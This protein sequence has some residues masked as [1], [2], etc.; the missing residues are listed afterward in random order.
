MNGIG[1]S[2]V[3]NSKGVI[4]S[5]NTYPFVKIQKGLGVHAE[6]GVQYGKHTAWFKSE[7]IATQSAV[8]LAKLYHTVGTQSSAFLA[9][10]K[11]TFNLN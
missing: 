3:I 4:D 11:Q 6:Y 10:A 8:N 7:D 1:E 2:V 9:T 5:S